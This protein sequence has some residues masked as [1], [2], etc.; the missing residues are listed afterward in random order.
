MM[1]LTPIP[2]FTDNYIWCLRTPEGAALLVD[3]GDREAARHYVNAHRLTVQAILITHH[4]ADHIGGVPALRER[5]P[6]AEVIGPDSS[7]VGPLTCALTEGQH[8]QWQGIDFR[9]M[10]SPGHTLDHGVFFAE[11]VPLTTPVPVL[12]CGDTLFAGGCGR[13]FE[14]TPAQ[15]RASLAKLRALPD[16]TLVCCAHEYTLSNYRYARSVHTDPA[17]ETYIKSL[18]DLREKG[19][20]TLPTRLADE[21]RFNPF[22]RWDDPTI[23]AIVQRRW[24]IEHAPDS[25][26]PQDADA[27]FACLRAWKDHFQ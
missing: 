7:R 2:A 18:E 11:R 26:P 12:F 19:Q 22:L 10:Q 8:W 20:P 24:A 27:I 25:L 17:L 13:L 4:H 15:M 14:G 3:P 23:R 9:F 6:D 5:F 1:T 16:D 21:R